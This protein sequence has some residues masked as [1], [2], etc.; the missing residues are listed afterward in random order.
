MQNNFR[1]RLFRAYVLNAPWSFS[2]A[3][4]G[5]KVFMED[6][7]ASKV[8]ISCDPSDRSMLTFINPSQLEPKFAGSAPVVNQYWPPVLPP[9]DI[10]VQ[11]NPTLL[12][13]PEEYSSLKSSGKLNSSKISPFI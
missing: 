3:Y 13:S 11:S 6:S 5:I 7:T 9:R 12:V 1:G 8:V 2:T 10:F 4:S